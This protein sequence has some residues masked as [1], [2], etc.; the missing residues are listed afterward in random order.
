MNGVA[1]TMSAAPFCSSVALTLPRVT[2]ADFYP[3][4]SRYL[5]TLDRGTQTAAQASA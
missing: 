3:G 2:H 4:I 5:D 1:D